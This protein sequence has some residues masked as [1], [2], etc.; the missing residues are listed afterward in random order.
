VSSQ[1]GRR[2]EACPVSTGGRGGGGACSFSTSSTTW[3]ARAAPTHSAARGV[4]GEAPQLSRVPHGGLKVVLK[5]VSGT[6]VSVFTKHNVLRNERL[7][8]QGGRN[9]AEE[10][11]V[12]VLVR[13]SLVPRVFVPQSELQAE[14]ALSGRAGKCCAARTRSGQGSDFCGR[15]PAGTAR[16]LQVR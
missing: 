4:R 9:L 8:P 11:G 13:R 6:D 2:D 15:P 1:Y 12:A 16:T 10:P 3:I 5:K 14:R 7:F